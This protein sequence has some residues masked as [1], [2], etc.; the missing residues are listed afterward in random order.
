MARDPNIYIFP[1]GNNPN[2]LAL[3][4][5]TTSRVIGDV[6]CDEK[7]GHKDPKAQMI[8]RIFA[9]AF[10]MFAE[11][12]TAVLSKRQGVIEYWSGKE[13]RKIINEIRGG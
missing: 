5:D 4:D 13:A 9:N 11:L 1:D 7:F 2:S 3:Y 10:K 12:E 6:V 8:A